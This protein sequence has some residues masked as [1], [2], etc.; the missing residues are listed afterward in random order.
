MSTD[1][2]RDLGPAY[3]GSRLKRLGERMQAGAARVTASA[4]LPMQPSHMPLLAALDGRVLSIGE[5][6]AAVGISQPGVTRGINQLVKLGLVQ[7]Q[8]CSDQRRRA[9]SMT[10]AGAAAFARARVHV[11]PALED[12]LGGLTD[13]QLHTFMRQL[14]TLESALG[15][16]PLD[17]LAAREQHDVLSVREYDDALAGDFK[18]I[19][20]EWINSMFQLEDA[21]RETL[22]HPREKIIDV[23]GTIL[24]VEARGLGIVGAGALMP[25]KPA[26]AVELTK[27]GVLE[28]ARGLK[29]GEFLLRALIERAQTMH[30]APLFLLTNKRC[31]A[32]VHLYEKLGFKHDKAIMAR[33]GAEYARCDVAMQYTPDGSKR[34][35]IPDRPGTGT[36][37][38]RR[39]PGAS[40][41]RRAHPQ[42]QA[43]VDGDR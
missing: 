34:S 27:L 15:E 3:L 11:I 39:P 26:H 42:T 25:A 10:P 8:P 18:D 31:A 30:A 19:N 5:L 1:L 32:A 14:A 40:T 6:V 2:L 23:G 9:V 43:M 29:A 22:D 35:A 4:N 20:L 16:T 28:K 38:R 36:P 21:D 33:Y 17:V 12:A 7:S 13:D 41:G 37:G 24:F